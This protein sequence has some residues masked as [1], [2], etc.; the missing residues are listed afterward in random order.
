MSLAFGSTFHHKELTIFSQI[1]QNRFVTNLNSL[2][3]HKSSHLWPLRWCPLRAPARV[4]WSLPPCCAPPSAGTCPGSPTTSACSIPYCHS[5]WLGGNAG[6]SGG[7]WEL[8]EK[9]WD[10]KMFR[11]SNNSLSYVCILL[12]S[13]F[14]FDFLD[15]FAWI[16]LQLV[17][18][19]QFNWTAEDWSDLCGINASVP[20]REL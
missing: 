3:L 6:A 17:I 9:T 12:K 11:Q 7:G 16:M 4:A 10:S 14:F 15:I 2:K 19:N 20:V 18:F 8:H 5:W 13:A 1:S